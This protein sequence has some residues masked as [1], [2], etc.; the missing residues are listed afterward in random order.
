MTLLTQK[1]KSLEYECAL[2]CALAVLG[3]NWYTR[4]KPNTRQVMNHRDAGIFQAYLN[5]QLNNHEPD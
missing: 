1:V 5:E 2:V 4:G 3:V